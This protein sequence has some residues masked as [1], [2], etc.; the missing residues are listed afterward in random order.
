VRTAVR[1]EVVDA[2]S[3]VHRWRDK[4]NATG[5]DAPRLRRAWG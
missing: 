2:D 5:G 3:D 4:R 1:A